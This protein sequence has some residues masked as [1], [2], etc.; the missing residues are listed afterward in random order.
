MTTL[1][2]YWVVS[3]NVKDDKTKDQRSVEQWKQA[4]LHDYVAVMGWPPYDYDHGHAV[5]PRFADDVKNG[6]VVLIARKKWREPEVVAVGVVSSDLKQE[7]ENYRK[8]HDKGPVY[9]RKLHPFKTTRQGPRDALLEV[10]KCNWAMHELYPDRDDDRYDS[11]R[12]ICAWVNQQ[13]G[14]ASNGDNSIPITRKP[15]GEEGHKSKR[16]YD[17]EVRNRKK[18]TTARRKEKE[19]LDSYRQWL[20]KQGREL[21]RLQIGQME[22]DAWDE[23]KRNLIE[24]KGTVSREDIRMAVGQL[25]DYAYQI[26]KRLGEPNKAIL[27]P[28]KPDWIDLGWVESVG[29][30]I[31]WRSGRRFE[32]NAGGQFT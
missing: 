11:H 16:T 19:L 10:L 12:K 4:I 14:L 23:E 9:V 32:D 25:F 1:R 31:V 28:K 29:I 22:C 2:R 3:P 6:D 13:L 26:G 7:D 8:I 15:L 5:G 20:K 30:K 18:V 17:Y 21:S 27:L 24:A